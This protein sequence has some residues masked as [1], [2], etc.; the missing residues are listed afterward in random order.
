M[1]KHTRFQAEGDR[2]RRQLKHIQ[3]QLAH[4]AHLLRTEIELVTR[5]AQ[6][7]ALRAKGPA[8]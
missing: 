4:R 7:K 8:P 5:Q 3:E 2:I 6:E 1:K